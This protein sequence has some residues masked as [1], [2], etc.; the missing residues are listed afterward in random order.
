MGPEF[1]GHIVLRV[2]VARTTKWKF[3][4]KLFYDV[5]M[6]L[7][8]HILMNYNCLLNTCNITLKF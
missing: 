7:K 8:V 3:I 6:V 2:W 4:N 5:V 1:S